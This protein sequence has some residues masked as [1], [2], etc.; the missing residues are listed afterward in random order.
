MCYSIAS[1]WASYID[2][3][4]NTITRATRPRFNTILFR[5][6][7]KSIG[8]FVIT[9]KSLVVVDVTLKS[10]SNSISM[11]ELLDLYKNRS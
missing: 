2:L 4:I 9:L 7:N 5:S 11:R 3:Y 6:L 8:V 10:L 1:T